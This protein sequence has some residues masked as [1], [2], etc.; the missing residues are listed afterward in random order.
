MEDANGVLLLGCKELAGLDFSLNK[1]W[2]EKEVKLSVQHWSPV[3]GCAA[4]F[5]P[6]C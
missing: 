2:Q 5:A 3:A 1:W 4:S 6:Q